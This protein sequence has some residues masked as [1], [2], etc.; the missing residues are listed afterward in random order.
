MI[1]EYAVGDSFGRPA[2]LLCWAALGTP[3]L[4][5]GICK[6]RTAKKSPDVGV[7]PVE[8]RLDALDVRPP[9]VGG[10]SRREIG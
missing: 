9:L 6:E 5:A 8:D 1:V 2:Q 7:V 4:F 10:R 3:V